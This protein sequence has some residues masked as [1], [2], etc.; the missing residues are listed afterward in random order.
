MHQ[1]N[2]TEYRVVQLKRRIAELKEKIGYTSSSVKSDPQTATPKNS[3]P[4][5]PSHNAVAHKTY[6]SQRASELDS[7]KNQLQKRT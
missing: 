4:V 3:N 1:L 7:L 2:D 5:P 6:R